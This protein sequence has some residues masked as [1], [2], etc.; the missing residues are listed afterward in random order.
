MTTGVKRSQFAYS[1]YF[2][3]FCAGV[4]IDPQ[5]I[6]NIDSVCVIHLVFLFFYFWWALFVRKFAVCLINCLFFS[7]KK[8]LFIYFKQS[9]DFFQFVCKRFALPFLT[10][11]LIQ[12][13]NPYL[14]NSCK[15]VT[16]FAQVTVINSR[17]TGFCRSIRM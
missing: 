6:S 5:K 7:N 15:Y 13:H 11:F 16:L 14:W 3:F 2:C 1:F 17:L 10:R 4:T 9:Q 8:K 12:V